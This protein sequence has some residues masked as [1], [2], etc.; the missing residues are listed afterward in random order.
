[1]KEAWIS[2][3]GRVPAGVLTDDRELIVT[4]PEVENCLSKNV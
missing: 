4:P 2:S 3:G 1:M